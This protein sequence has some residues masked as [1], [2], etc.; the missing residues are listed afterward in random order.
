MSVCYNC[1][2]KSPRCR[3]SCELF[4]NNKKKSKSTKSKKFNKS[5]YMRQFN[6]F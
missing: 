6:N 2:H 1:K 3:E 4:R 5:N